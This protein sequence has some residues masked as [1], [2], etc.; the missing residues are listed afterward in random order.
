MVHGTAHRQ[1]IGREMVKA[2][3]AQ[4]SFKP[5]TQASGRGKEL[6]IQERKL[7]SRLKREP[8]TPEIRACCKALASFNGSN[9]RL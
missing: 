3:R 8:C 1:E 2:L 9:R 7:G 6:F 4:L 5:R